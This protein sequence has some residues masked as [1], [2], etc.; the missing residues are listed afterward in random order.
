MMY[1]YAHKS[2]LFNA[3]FR[4]HAEKKFSP[5]QTFQGV[6]CSFFCQ[7]R[8]QVKKKVAFKHLLNSLA[9]LQ[10]GLQSAEIGIK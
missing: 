4:S 10:V 5:H 8:K 6:G 9:R 2:C 1:I 7:N 3:F